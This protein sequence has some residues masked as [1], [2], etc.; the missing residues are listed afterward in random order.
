MK[1]QSNEKESKLDKAA[2]L[3]ALG[4]S[5]SKADNATFAA[6]SDEE[7][8]AMLEG[9]LDTTRRAQI[10]DSMAND[11]ETFARWMAL[12]ETADTLGLESFAQAEAVTTPGFFASIA[13]SLRNQFKTLAA[14]GTGLAAAASVFLIFS[15]DSGLDSDIEDLYSSHGS[16]W[17]Q[18]PVEQISTRSASGLLKKTLSAEDKALKQGVL[19]GIESLGPEFSLQGANKST[20]ATDAEI[21]LS[22]KGYALLHSTGEIAALVHFK[23]ALGAEPEFYSQTLGLL[24]ALQPEL[25]A[26]EGATHQAL[27]KVISRS[28]DDET[29][30]C[31]FGKT[32]LDRVAL[33]S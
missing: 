21:D 11:S 18:M 20:T 27:D 26:N 32:V 31:R 19:K 28:G 22:D 16:R 9:K 1:N 15:G 6:P 24:E 4:L 14:S 23:C 29:R 5:Q 7:L 13:E 3:L 25:S 17:S 12:V 10:M 30:V 2:A 33:S 8:A